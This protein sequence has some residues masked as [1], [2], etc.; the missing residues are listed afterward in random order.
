MSSQSLSSDQL[1]ALEDLKKELG[2]LYN[3]SEHSDALLTRFL[4]ARRYDIPKTKAMFEAYIAWRKEANVE[5]IVQTFAFTEIKEVEKYY[6]RFYHKTDKKG[7]PIY[8]EIMGNLDYA[9]LFK[10]T[11]NERMICS[12]IRE[13]E[14]AQRYRM[15]AA[16]KKA[17]R[18]I[19]QGCTILDLK[20]VP[21]SQFNS[22]RRLIGILSEISQNYYPETLGK[23]FIINAPTLFTTIWVVVRSF[24]DENTVRKISVLGS[25]YQKDL[26]EEID[27]ANLPVAYG[28]TCSCPGGCDKADIGPWNDGSVEGYP[29]TFW[30]DFKKRDKG[31]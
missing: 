19:E 6:P 20:G 29:D 7:R 9:S 15:V 23:M 31:M 13:S 12:H 3:P 18:L 5:H 11:N 25:S 21:L 27:P 2:A 30:E 17:G 26:F 22:V 14:K 1:A 4:R 24:L 28:G 8:Y 16:S 10:V